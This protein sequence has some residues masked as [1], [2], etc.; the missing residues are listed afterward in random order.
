MQNND[1]ELDAIFART[2]QLQYDQETILTNARYFE[3]EDD[4]N[5]ESFEEE[6]QTRENIENDYAIAM[7][8]QE[9]LNEEVLNE[10]TDED[11]PRTNQYGHFRGNFGRYVNEATESNRSYYSEDLNDESDD[12]LNKDLRTVINQFKTRLIQKY[13]HTNR[14]VIRL[15]SRNQLLMFSEFIEAIKLFK[16]VDFIQRPRI[17]F[18][19][20]PVI[21]GGGA[22]NDTIRQILD[23]F[24]SLENPEYGGNGRLFTGDSSKLISSTAPI[25]VLDELNIFGDI[26]FLAIIHEAP[27]PV[28]LDIILFKYCL[29]LESTITLKDVERFNPVM[30][31]LARNVLNADPDVDL[32]TIDGFDQWAED[33]EISKIQKQVYS[34]SR[35]NLRKLA[36]EISHDVLIHC[37]IKQ[38]NAI[39]LK[40]NKFGFLNVVKEKQIGIEQIKDYFYQDSITFEDIIRK[41]VFAPPH[42]NRRQ[43]MVRNWLNEWLRAQR[44]EE[45]QEFCRL[46]TGFSHPREEITVTFKPYIARENREAALTP[47]FQTCFSE[48]K[49]SEHFNSKH[50]FFAIMNAQVNKNLHDSR[51]T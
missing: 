48:I 50:E 36:R 16:E 28:D 4:E 45:L 25:S 46:T 9:A 13:P 17:E 29:D 6:Q 1:T 30:C 49:I 44:K 34:R 31:N 43:N 5:D 51:F 33:K 21:D 40:L 8:L 20:E 39:K 10:N 18:R 14:K 11:S 41:L 26:L 38:L 15:S 35:E 2:L 47:R 42:L 3:Y 23:T 12:D 32:S 37:R 22:F 24:M 27:F 7:Q 19:N